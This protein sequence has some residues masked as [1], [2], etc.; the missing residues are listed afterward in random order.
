MKFEVVDPIPFSVS[1]AFTLLRD[2]MGS[3]V[4]YMADTEEI[5]VINREELDDAVKITNKWRA[6]REKI[7]GALRSIVKPEMLSWHDYATWTESDHTG[8]WELEALGS[9]KLF[10]CNGETS[11]YEE[12]G[13]T[14]LKISID[15]Q[16]YP[17]RVPG[18]PKFLAKKLGGQ[19]EKVI[20]EMLS[21]NMRQMAQSMAAY[22]ASK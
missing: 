12:N 6:S 21:S 4:P 2:E 5:T 14:H 18:V 1:D 7:P 16:V 9:D 20:G 13:A 17:E 19:V 15:F 10:S 11:V 8:R 3:L 22:A